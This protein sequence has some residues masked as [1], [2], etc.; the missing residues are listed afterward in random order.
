M[1]EIV[2]LQPM[3]PSVVPLQRKMLQRL[4]SKQSAGE[5]RNSTRKVAEI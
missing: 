2:F 3:R 4:P 1:R 5:L